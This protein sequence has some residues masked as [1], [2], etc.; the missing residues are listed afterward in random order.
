M[1]RARNLAEA[2]IVVVPDEVY[3]GF[4]DEARDRIDDPDDAP[5]VAQSLALDAGVWTRERDFFRS[6]VATWRAEVMAHVLDL[7]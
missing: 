2:T 6:G 1:N 5:A 4:L 3:E 7:D